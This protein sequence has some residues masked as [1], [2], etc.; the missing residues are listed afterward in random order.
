MKSKKLTLE[1]FREKWPEL[2]TEKD[3]ELGINA[4]ATVDALLKNREVVA[5]FINLKSKRIMKERALPNTAKM[6]KILEK[7]ERRQKKAIGDKYG[8][9]PYAIGIT[10]CLA[11]ALSLAT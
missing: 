2:V 6:V 1:E 9:V 3:G 7:A 4:A 10:A 8:W 5:D 11:L